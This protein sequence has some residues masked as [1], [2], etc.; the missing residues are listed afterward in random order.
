MLSKA[1]ALAYIG[2]PMPLDELKPPG[3]TRFGAAVLAAGLHVI[4]IAALV[5][6]FA[7]QV[8]T[9]VLG[10]VVQAF[11]VTVT[12]PSPPPARA[13]AAAPKRE[14]AAAA[15]GRKARPRETAAPVPKIVLSPTRAPALPDTG[16]AD[17][18]GAGA[19]G[20]GTGAGGA[21]SGT[22]AGGTGSGAGGGGGA[23]AVKIA[24]D[25]VSARD[26]PRATR[27]LRL[28]RSVT[29]ALTVGIDGQVK[30][31]HIVQPSGDPEADRITCRLATGRFRFRPA[32]DVTGRPIESV[33]GWQQRWFMP[34][35]Q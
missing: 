18:A 32:R 31:C 6:A 17:T 8:E 10:P 24:G 5:H 16:S 12:M 23:K 13:R 30:S 15:A 26:Y 4:V 2:W 11:D 9:R 27:S 34:T 22:G 7:S 28:G 33:Y 1:I 20:E 25:I 3:R 35:L 29:V 21:G 19:A 14:G